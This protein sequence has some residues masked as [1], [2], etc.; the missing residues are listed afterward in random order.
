APGFPEVATSV[1]GGVPTYAVVHLT[2]SAEPENDSQYPDAKLFS[3][4]DQWVGEGMIPDHQ[5]F[6]G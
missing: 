3:S 1:E 4:L 6:I 5:E 2:W